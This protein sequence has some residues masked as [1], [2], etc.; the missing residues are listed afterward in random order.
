MKS[1]LLDISGKLDSEVVY[2]FSCISGAAAKQAI[3][4]L[5]VGATA[6]DYLLELGCAL[7]LDP[8]RLRELR[9]E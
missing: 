3:D 6:R 7:S 4:I 5:V 8:E 1:T 2:A 9:A